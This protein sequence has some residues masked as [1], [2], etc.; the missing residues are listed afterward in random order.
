M[1]PKGLEWITV[2]VLIKGRFGQLIKDAE[3]NSIGFSSKHIKQI[4][5]NY[6]RAQFYDDYAGSLFECLIEYSKE[7]SLCDLNIKL[8][9]WITK[10]L[11]L[12]TKFIR[13]S[14]LVI[15]LQ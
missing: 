8:I 5:Q 11:S 12:T 7:A 9:L 14:E 10:A 13:A 2:P 4:K 3:I 6:T 15:S 1:S